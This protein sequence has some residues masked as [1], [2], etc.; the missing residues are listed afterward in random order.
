MLL[1]AM[2]LASVVCACS[3]DDDADDNWMVLDDNNSTV[4]VEFNATL[5]G[6]QGG[7]ASGESLTLDRFQAYGFNC[8]LGNSVFGDTGSKL[9]QGVEVVR[10]VDDQNMWDYADTKT[11]AMLK[12]ATL[13]K[14]PI[15]F[16]GISGT[17]A[18]MA[19]I[20]SK[21]NLPTLKVELPAGQ[22]GMVKSNE[23]NDLLFASALRLDP[24]QYLNDST[25]IELEFGHLLPMLS[26]RATLAN[27]NDLD[28]TVKSVILQGLATAAEYDFNAARPAWDATDSRE[29]ALALSQPVTLDGTLANLQDR[30]VYLIPQALRGWSGPGC[31]D[32]AGIKILARIRSKASGTY[33]AGSDS[34]FG[35][36]YVALD[37]VN[38]TSGNNYTLDVTFH[39]IYNAD[40]SIGLR[41]AYKPVVTPWVEKDDNLILQ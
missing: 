40:G 4:Y 1:G 13:I 36:V 2:L 29:I 15:S 38:L 20:G 28:V 10:N 18:N 23:T 34:E 33:L 12:W 26:L 6:A 31:N 7:V 30:G 11:K 27:T 35:E 17:G 16:Y 14:Y 39:S 21:N 25:K 24:R 5:T 22:D 3:G 41:A 19:K 8:A 32:G 37:N 9:A